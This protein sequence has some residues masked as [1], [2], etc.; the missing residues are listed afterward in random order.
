MYSK[1]RCR[2]V[3]NRAIELKKMLKV[4]SGIQNAT[5]GDV[6]EGYL[7]EVCVQAKAYWRNLSANARA[8]GRRGGRSSLLGLDRPREVVLDVAKENSREGW[9]S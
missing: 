3:A 6:P 7:C 8:K 4:Q 9:E 1:N 2:D 5:R